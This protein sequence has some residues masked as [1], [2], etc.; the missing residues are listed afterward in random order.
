MISILEQIVWKNGSNIP[1]DQAV[2][3]LMTKTVFWKFDQ[4]L[5]DEILILLFKFLREFA[6]RFFNYFW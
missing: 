1:V 2:L 5:F 6:S 3:E 4:E